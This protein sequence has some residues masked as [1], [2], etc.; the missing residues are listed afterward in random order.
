[1]ILSRQDNTRRKKSFGLVRW[2]RPLVKQR[3]AIN[4][5]KI[6]RKS[7]TTPGLV[8][9][10]FRTCPKEFSHFSKCA[11]QTEPA[12]I[13]SRIGTGMFVFPLRVRQ[14]I[15]LW[16]WFVLSSELRLFCSNSKSK[17]LRSKH[18]SIIATRCMTVPLHLMRCLAAFES[19]R[20]RSGQ[21]C[22]FCTRD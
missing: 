5:E 12:M 8:Q 15:S 1:M 11:I 21:D 20:A 7:K 22:Y 19:N 2:T 17:D 13:C 3:G 10:T 18:C 14:G 16:L 9:H 4:K 6:R